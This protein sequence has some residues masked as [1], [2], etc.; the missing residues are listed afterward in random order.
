VQPYLYLSRRQWQFRRPALCLCGAK[1]A[2]AVLL[3]SLER[4]DAGADQ[5]V[6]ESA[7]GI[8]FALNWFDKL[9][10]REKQVG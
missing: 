4:A 10:A 7:G 1:W 8:F 2:R 5:V 9:K 3:G 6:R